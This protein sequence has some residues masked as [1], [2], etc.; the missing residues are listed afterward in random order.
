[1]VRPGNIKILNPSACKVIGGEVEYDGF[2]LRAGGNTGLWTMMYRNSSIQHECNKLLRK[3]N[4]M[5]HSRPVDKRAL[6]GP[7]PSG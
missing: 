4:S 5:R 6:A 1:M 3:Y 2:T 7:L